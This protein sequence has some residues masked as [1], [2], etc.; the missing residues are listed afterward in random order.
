VT[1]YS[2]TTFKRQNIWNSN[3]GLI[4]KSVLSSFHQTP[5]LLLGASQ[6]QVGH[7][8]NVAFKKD[9]SYFADA[10]LVQKLLQL[11]FGL[12]SNHPI[13]SVSDSNIF[14]FLCIPG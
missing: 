14:F 9:K 5:S 8:M 11:L 10:V 6:M 2:Q 7:L 12:F 3:K 13:D 1:C 4:P